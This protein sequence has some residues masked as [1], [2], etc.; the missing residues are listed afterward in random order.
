MIPLTP[1]EI[2]EWVNRMQLSPR[3][4]AQALG[5][6]NADTVMREYCSGDRRE[7]S[8]STRMH[9]DLLEQV[10]DAVMDLQRN[11]PEQAQARLKQALLVRFL[12]IEVQSP[13]ETK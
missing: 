10:R 6:G 9:M 12:G 4:A 1:V 13:Q 7:P 5:L 11:K 3:R 2:R 8:R